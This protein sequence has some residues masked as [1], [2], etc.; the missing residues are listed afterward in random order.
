MRLGQNLLKK[1]VQYV[2]GSERIAER[3]YFVDTVLYFQAN[4]VFFF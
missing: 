1:R 2:R 3:V 4:F